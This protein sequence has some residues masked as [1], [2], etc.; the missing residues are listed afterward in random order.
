MSLANDLLRNMTVEEEDDKTLVINHYTRSIII[1][2]SITTLGVENDDDVLRLEFRMPRYLGT[3]DLSKFSIRVNYINAEGEDGFYKVTDSRVVGDNILFSW[4]VGPT[5]TAY[6]GSTKFN[7][8]M[9]LTDAQSTVLQEYNTAIASLPV[10]EGMEVDADA[11]TR[12][13]DILEQWESR[14]FGI[15][16]TEE[17]KLVAVSEEEQKNIAQ[18]AGVV[19]AS[20][21]ADY[22]TTSK[23]ADKAERT[24]ADAIIC[25]AE[26]E[27]VKMEDSSDDKLRGLRI[28][29]KTSQVRT[30]GYQKLPYPYNQTT[31]VTNGITYTDNGDGSITISGTATANA[32]F[33]MYNTPSPAIPGDYILSGA[34]KDSGCKFYAYAG[35]AYKEDTGSGAI[36]TGDV[37]SVHIVVGSGTTINTTVYPMLSVGKVM[38]WEPY[39]GGVASPSPEWPQ[40]LVSIGHSGEINVC[41]SGKNII[42]YPYDTKTTTISG[43]T[44]TVNDDGTIKLDGTATAGVWFALKQE[45]TLPAGAYAVKVLPDNWNDAN[46]YVIWNGKGGYFHEFR[47]TFTETTTCG[48]SITLY[49]G[50]VLNNVVLKPQIESGTAFTEYEPPKTQTLTISDR[51][52]PGIPVTSG[53]NYTDANGQ[54]WICDEIDFKRGVYVQRV[55]KLLSTYG[56]KWA[57]SGSTAENHNAFYRINTEIPTMK[58]GTNLPVISSHFQ[59]ST[60]ERADSVHVVG[61]ID[62]QEIYYFVPKADFP[63]ANTWA[64]YTVAQADAGTPITTYYILTTPIETPLT[65]SDLEAFKALHSNYPTTTV[66]NDSGAHMLVTYNA[67]TKTWIENLIESKI[68]AYLEG[69]DS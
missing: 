35:G 50:A 10:L 30:N 8:N 65:A 58:K 66:L 55:Y 13:I 61:G 1:P 49:K 37:K 21:P 57:L 39:S 5:A 53:G 14:L 67:D 60:D 23:L 46:G 40:E 12:Y 44:I 11:I 51:D 19:M 68:A 3:V 29:G 17:A 9:V 54:Q 59:M 6:K 41:V 24:K 18:H 34:P 36:L 69:A 56:D 47:T 16:D 62:N 52:I 26:G 42:P 20:I 27:V 63:D 2:K 31:R 45:F 4:L 38:P 15:S 33:D 48:I 7:V 25:S 22:T 64:A 43:V 32:Y 28:F